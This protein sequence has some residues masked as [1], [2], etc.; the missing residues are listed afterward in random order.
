MVAIS[1]CMY[2]IK[3]IKLVVFKALLFRI[4]LPVVYPRLHVYLHY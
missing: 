3:K 4:V 2:R 1:D